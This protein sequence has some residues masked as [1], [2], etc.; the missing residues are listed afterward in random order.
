M[1]FKDT[2]HG[3]KVAMTN[4]N[5]RAAVDEISTYLKKN[6]LPHVAT[7]KA[8]LAALGGAEDDD[9]DWPYRVEPAREENRR[10]GVT[11]D[12]NRYWRQPEF[13]PADL[14]RT[15][16]RPRRK[17]DVLVASFPDLA[18]VRTDQA[19][20]YESAVD[21]SNFSELMA[22]AG[23]RD[24]IGGVLARYVASIYGR[25]CLFSVHQDTISGWMAR[26]RSVVLEDLQSF[27][28]PTEERSLFT[29][30][31]PSD[32]YVGEI[33]DNPADRELVLALADPAPT[34]VVLV[35]IRVKQRVVAYLLCDNPGEATPRDRVEKVV[36]ACRKAGVAFE[37]LILRR[38]LAS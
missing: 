2:K 30:V 14:F 18:E 26:G 35:P 32:S 13:Q 33:G 23:H 25:V 31:G 21:D 36:M 8:V 20:F 3:V 24:E 10:D 34:D 7:E 12:W 29:D 37:I 27:G 28:V 6:V 15:A 11:E 22:D 17:L 19:G 16:P 38:K 4:P 1:P 9:A 5:D